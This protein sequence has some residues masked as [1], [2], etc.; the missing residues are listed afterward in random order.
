MLRDVALMWSGRLSDHSA[1]RA[2]ALTAAINPAKSLQFRAARAPISTAQR[3]WQILCTAAKLAAGSGPHEYQ[4]MWCST[5]QQETPG[6]AHAT[7]GRFVC[8]RCQRPMPR[9]NST[10]TTRICDEGLA[11]DEPQ[12]AATTATGTTPFR[13]D[14]WAAGQRVRKAVRELRRPNPTTATST[15]RIAS[16]RRRFDPPRDSVRRT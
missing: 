5:C 7:S 11:L 15:N 9:R 3:N 10:H 14:E 1:C 16:D 8:S 4:P 13:T 12:L 2:A 6:V